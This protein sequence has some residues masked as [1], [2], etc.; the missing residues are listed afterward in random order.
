MKTAE[1]IYM[2]LANAIQDAD[3]IPPCQ[4]TDP[5]I[6]FSDDQEGSGT[7]YK[8]ARQLC[9]EC[10]VQDLCL[11]FALVSEEQFGVWG[12]LS[13]RERRM[14]RVAKGRTRGRRANL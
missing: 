12:G 10:P 14:M 9:S 7:H 5:E 8:L 4:T 13:P 11:E 6:W 3:E 2:Q 1:Q